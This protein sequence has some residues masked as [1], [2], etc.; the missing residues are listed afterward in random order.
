MCYK[1][2]NGFLA[3]VIIIFSFWTTSFSWWVILIAAVIIL[4]GQLRY[5]ASCGCDGSLSMDGRPCGLT[6]PMGTSHHTGTELF[7]EKGTEELEPEPSKKEVR[8]TLKRPTKKK[9]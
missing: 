2:L 7:M 9:K 1:C 8:E 6:K 3:A 4:I 5:L